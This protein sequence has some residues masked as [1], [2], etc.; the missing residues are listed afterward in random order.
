MK[1]WAAPASPSSR[2]P[3]DRTKRQLE[4]AD[5]LAKA[6]EALLG[7]SRR[8]EMEAAEERLQACL[9]DFKRIRRGDRNG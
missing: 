2:P 4:A 6:A 8:E 7:V 3:E 5:A 9:F 1:L